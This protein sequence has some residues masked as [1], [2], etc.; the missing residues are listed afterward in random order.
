MGHLLAAAGGVLEEAV[1]SVDQQIA[2]VQMPYDTV[3]HR[4]HRFTGLD[5]ENNLSRFFQRVHELFHG[6]STN[7]ILA[8]GFAG[9]KS[10]GLG[11]GAVKDRNGKALA[12]DVQGQVLPHDR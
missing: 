5:H 12:L 8:L 9:E 2:L 6:F 3:N 11:C 1:A 7:Y 4:V 10:L